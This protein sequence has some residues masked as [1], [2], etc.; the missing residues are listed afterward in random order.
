MADRTEG[1][2]RVEQALFN[3]TDADALRAEFGDVWDTDGLH[4]DFDV[5]G[6]MAPYVVVK[7]KADGVVGS[8]QF[9]HSPR[10]YF[11]FKPDTR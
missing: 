4:R 2:R 1:I 9:K 11:N 3:N 7:R 6:F 8:L 10:L 5:Q